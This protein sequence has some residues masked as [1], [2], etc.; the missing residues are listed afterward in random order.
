MDNFLAQN[1]YCRKVLVKD[2]SCVFRAVSETLFLTQAYHHHVRQTCA[3]YHWRHQEEELAGIRDMMALSRIYQLEFFVFHVPGM[4]P[5]NVTESGHPTQICLVHADNCHYDLVQSR[6]FVQDLAIC[7]S[8]VYEVLYRGVFGLTGELQEAVSFI[9]QQKK[10]S[11]DTNG[12]IFA[13]PESLQHLCGKE[14]HTKGGG[15]VERATPPL[16]YR[17][18][19]ALDP[20]L[21]RN[22]ELDIVQEEKREIKLRLQGR[23]LYGVF[24]PGDKCQ[25]MRCDWGYWGLFRYTLFLAHFL[26]P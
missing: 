26:F 6:A 4:S 17:I 14:P 7:Q 9:R 1:G 20:V 10:S 23:G 13:F 12:K 21:Y 24:C 22:V 2:G 25:H 8:V 15:S 18:A 3:D 5:L 16:P 11:L 19:K